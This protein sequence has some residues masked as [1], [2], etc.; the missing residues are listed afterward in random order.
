MIYLYKER[1]GIPAGIEP[2][3]DHKQLREKEKVTKK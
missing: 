1:T 2:N 3:G